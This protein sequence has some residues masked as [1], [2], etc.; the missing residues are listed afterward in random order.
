MQTIGTLPGKSSSVASGINAL[1]QV[2][3]HAGDLT[4]NDKAFL[5][6]SGVMQDIGTLGGTMA[7]AMSINDA[8]QVVGRSRVIGGSLHAFLWEGGVMQDL[9]TLGGADSGATDINSSGQIVGGSR[10]ASGEYHAFLWGDGVMQDL[11]TLP[12]T[13][14]GTATGINSKG[15]VVGIMQSGGPTPNNYAFL[16]DKGTMLD[17]CVLSNCTAQGWDYLLQANDINEAGDIIGVGRI[18]GENRA[19]LISAVPV[20][21]GVWLFA[22]GLLGLVGIARR[23]KAV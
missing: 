21:A 17:L 14:T 16:W 8:S 13:S 18:A 11:G 6:D 5:W 20:P 12:G 4:A 1:G 10:T 19:F 9:G 3:G 15:Q 7:Q 2:V 23:K 22:S